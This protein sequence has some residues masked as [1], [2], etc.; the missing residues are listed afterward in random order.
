M[1][2]AR[3]SRATGLATVLAATAVLAGCSK[4]KGEN[5][6]P[7]EAIIIPSEVTIYT[8][9]ANKALNVA[10]CLS[11][12]LSYEDGSSVPTGHLNAV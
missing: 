1:K 2:D 6:P 10:S 9:D 8:D 5:V 12:V 11:Y 7:E 4:E 3:K